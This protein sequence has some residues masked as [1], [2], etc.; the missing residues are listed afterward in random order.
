MRH[1]TGYPEVQPAASIQFGIPK[2]IP[3]AFLIEQAM[4][5]L[6]DTAIPRVRD[7]LNIL[8][9]LEQQLVDAQC[10]LVADKVGEI[11]LAGA[12]DK[13]SRLVTERLET[14]YVRWAKRL[15][16]IFGVPLYPFSSRFMSKRYGSIPVT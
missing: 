7:I 16:D 9:N 8:D 10:Q 6:L 4:E 13:K 2:P 3:L 15:V 5:N 11:T 14:E 12:L 1:H